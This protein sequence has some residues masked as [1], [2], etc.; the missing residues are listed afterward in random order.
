MSA[1][2]EERRPAVL[3]GGQLEVVD[4]LRAAGVLSVSEIAEAIG[5]SRSVATIRVEE[6]VRLGVVDRRMDPEDRRRRQ[7]R[8]TAAWLPDR[9]GGNGSG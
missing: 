1:G 2:G 3:S 6:L 7:V 5:A 8:L 9:A 4:A